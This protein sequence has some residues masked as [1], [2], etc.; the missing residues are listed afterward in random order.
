MAITRKSYVYIGD[1]GTEHI[2]P[3]EDINYFYYLKYM[4][5]AVVQRQGLTLDQIRH[6]YPIDGTGSIDSYRFYKEIYDDIMSDV[7]VEFA[8]EKVDL[9]YS[10][11]RWPAKNWRD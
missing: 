10:Y 2:L 1:R 11:T 9:P 5:Q 7:K 3:R 4:P 8:N 6:I